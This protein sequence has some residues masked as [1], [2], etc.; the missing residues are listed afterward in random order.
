MERKPELFAFGMKIMNKVLQESD[1][2]PFSKKRLNKFSKSS[3]YLTAK[4]KV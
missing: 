2:V 1:I 3:L 4:Q